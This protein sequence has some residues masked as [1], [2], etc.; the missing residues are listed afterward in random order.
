MN[1]GIVQM[2]KSLAAI[3]ALAVA[4]CLIGCDASSPG[5]N[6]STSA[7]IPVSAIDALTCHLKTSVFAEIGPLR[8]IRS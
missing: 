5:T 8:A 2:L 4:A 6:N 7:H 1:L 3:T